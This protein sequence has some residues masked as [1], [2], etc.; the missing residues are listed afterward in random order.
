MVEGINLTPIQDPSLKKLKFVLP[1]V[2]LMLRL[3][4]KHLIPMLGSRENQNLPVKISKLLHECCNGIIMTISTPNAQD[5]AIKVV[6]DYQLGSGKKESKCN[7]IEIMT[8]PSEG[9]KKPG[10]VFYPMAWKA[11]VG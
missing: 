11:R 9:E 6:L 10:S 1:E 2:Q 3:T 8:Y 5:V 7:I 4:L